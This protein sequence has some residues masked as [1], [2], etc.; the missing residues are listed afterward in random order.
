MQDDILALKAKANA[1]QADLLALVQKDAEVFE[2]LSKA[3]GLPKDTDEQR[4]EKAKVLEA[5]LQGACAVP[6]SIMEKCCDAILLHKEFAAKGTAI[7]ISDVGVGVALCK[8]AL[9]GASLNVFINTKLMSDKARAD[10][11]NKRAGDMLDQ[12][13]SMADEIYASVRERLN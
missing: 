8:A 7:A 6:L 4:A 10:S 2:P 1:L 13:T 12:Y 11:I 9:L 3:Y 5:A